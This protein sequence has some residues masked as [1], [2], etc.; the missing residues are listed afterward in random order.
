MR[1]LTL[2]AALIAAVLVYVAVNQP[3]SDSDV[4]AAY[5]VASENSIQSRNPRL[6]ASPEG[7]AEDFYETCLKI[8]G[9]PDAEE[10]R[11]RDVLR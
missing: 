5:T 11:S 6:G 1:V 8:M 4:C 9:S 2:L 3:P 7:W 10:N